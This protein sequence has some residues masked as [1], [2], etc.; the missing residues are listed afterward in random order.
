MYHSTRPSASRPTTTNAQEVGE[1]HEIYPLEIAGRPVRWI[2]F[3]MKKRTRRT[4]CRESEM[5]NEHHRRDPHDISLTELANSRL[6]P[7]A[8]KVTPPSVPH[9][10][11]VVAT[12]S[13]SSSIC[14]VPSL[15]LAHQVFLLIIL[16]SSSQTMM[17]LSSSNQAGSVQAQALTAN[18]S[19]SSDQYKQHLQMQASQH[20]QQ[21]NTLVSNITSNNNNNRGPLS[22]QASLHHRFGKVSTPDKNIGL[23]LTVPSCTRIPSARVV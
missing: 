7:Q 16:I 21:L 2:N 15:T 10:R 18:Q 13:S 11:L 17:N 23:A 3:K 1:T 5:T 12:A 19:Q 14:S 6:T 4:H 20:Q 8:L 9:K 22:K